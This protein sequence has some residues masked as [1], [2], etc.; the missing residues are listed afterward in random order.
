MDFV[1]H[2]H[3]E[4]PWRC[5]KGAVP[6]SRSQAPRSMT[7]LKH[8]SAVWSPGPAGDS[9][10][11]PRAFPQNRRSAGES[12]ADLRLYA[13]AS[14][15]K[16]TRAPAGDSYAFQSWPTAFSPGPAGNLTDSGLHAGAFALKCTRAPG[17]TSKCVEPGVSGT[18][19]QL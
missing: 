14:A 19:C 15:F 12:P 11:D 7:P 5:F 1:W 6:P 16:C 2:C 17:F 13:G 18:S 3:F 9:L 8:G 10:A 4:T